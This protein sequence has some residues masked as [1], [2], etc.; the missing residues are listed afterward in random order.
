MSSRKYII[1]QITKLD[2]HRFICIHSNLLSLAVYDILTLDKIWH[3]IHTIYH[4]S[5]CFP[6]SL[7]FNV[8]MKRKFQHWWWTILPI[9]TKLTTMFVLLWYFLYPERVLSLIKVWRN[10]MNIQETVNRR[11]EN[12]MAKRKRWKVNNYVQNTG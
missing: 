4:E 11:T 5:A 9:S 2:I 1:P 7:Y 3:F 8:I 10:Q 6:T 12:T